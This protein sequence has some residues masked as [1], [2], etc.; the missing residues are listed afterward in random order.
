MGRYEV[1]FA[2]YDRFAEATGRV[3]PDDEGWGRGT[4]P[5]INVSRED[6][7][8]YAT[9]LSAQTGKP[10]R[11]PSEAEWEYAARADTTTAYSFGNRITC[12]QANFGRFEGDSCNTGNDA[13]LARTVAVGSFAA[14]AFGLYDMHGNVW[15]W[16]EDCWHDNY[17][18]APSDGSAWAS[19]CASPT[20]AIIRG[21]SWLSSPRS[22]RPANRFRFTPSNRRNLAGFRLVQ[23]LNP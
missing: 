6:A 12:E 22:L 11:L 7:R 3:K 14:N 4:R 2:E 20:R 16:V 18:G 15:E 19:G 17:E 13:S 23:D 1:S 21:G 8:A 9:W 5:A 10:Y